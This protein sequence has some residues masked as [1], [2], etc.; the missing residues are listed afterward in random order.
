MKIDKYK[1]YETGTSVGTAIQQYAAGKLEVGGTADT[2]V[3]WT[4]IPKA[5]I[6]EITK[7]AAVAADIAWAQTYTAGSFVAGNEWI[8]TLEYSDS[9]QKG[10]KVFKESFVLGDTDLIVCNR[11]R[12][13]VAASDLPLTGSGTT[14]LILTAVA[15]AGVNYVATLGVVGTATFTAGGATADAQITNATRLAAKFDGISAASFANVTDAFI[16]YTVKYLNHVASSDGEIGDYGYALVFVDDG[17]AVT[18]LDLAIN[19]PTVIA[20]DLATTIVV[21]NANFGQSAVGAV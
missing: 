9:R 2:L 11:F 19:G 14:T 16:V 21:A 20:S 8:L 7:A 18:V 1:I 10:R 12:A 3:N 4:G 15:G 13:Q 17:T 5:E 6:V